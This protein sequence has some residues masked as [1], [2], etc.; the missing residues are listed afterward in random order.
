MGSDLFGAAGASNAPQA[1]GNEFDFAGA[2]QA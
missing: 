1:Y 2:G